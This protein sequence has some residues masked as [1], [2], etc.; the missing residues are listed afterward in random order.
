LF[1]HIEGKVTDIEP[2]LAVIDCGGVG[3]ALNAS[4]N[5]IARLK[6]GERAK[7]YTYCYIREDSFDLYGFFTL[8]EKRCFEMLIG[9][10]GVGPKAA[11][12]ILS[13]STPEALTMAIISGN[14][15]ALTVAPG[16][17]KKIAQRVIL[18]LKDK[19]SKE[20]EQIAGAFAGAAGKAGAVSGGKLSD[21][22]AALTV[23]GY[24]NAEI[25][26]ALKD[27]DLENMSVEE[28]IKQSLK[29][30]LR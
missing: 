4:A 8:G 5:T 18:E 13:S 21:A 26:A 28:I 30:M 14:E 23:L 24:S 2:N 6:T 27:L 15:R 10:S 29:K 3:Y 9:V 1:Y 19:I 20:S 16:I 22:A 25:T 17:G 7:L 11:L 12:S